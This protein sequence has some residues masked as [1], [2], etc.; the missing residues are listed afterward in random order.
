MVKMAFGRDWRPQKES[1]RIPVTMP[2]ERIEWKR[3]ANRRELIGLVVE[4]ILR[5]RG[6]PWI[7]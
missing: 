3:H 1:A 7:R 5:T 4:F 6:L 2:A